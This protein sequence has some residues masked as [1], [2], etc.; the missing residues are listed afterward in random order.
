MS[1]AK[2]VPPIEVAPGHW[3]AFIAADL[4]ALFAQEPWL[5]LPPG[6][7]AQAELL[8]RLESTKPDDFERAMQQLG[9][10]S[11]AGSNSGGTASAADAE[12]TQANDPRSFLLGIMNDANIEMHLR[13]EAAKALLPYGEGKP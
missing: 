8:S 10:G 5:D 3:S 9:A 12:R 4:A 11:A 1:A 13:I 6:D 7:D 2:A